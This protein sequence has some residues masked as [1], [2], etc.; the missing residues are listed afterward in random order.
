MKWTYVN[1]KEE[2]GKPFLDKPKKEAYTFTMK[3]HTV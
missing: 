3:L 2:T 1:N